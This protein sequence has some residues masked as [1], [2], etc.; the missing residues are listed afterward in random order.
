MAERSDTIILGILAHVSAL[1]AFVHVNEGTQN[2][3][4]YMILYLNLR[5]KEA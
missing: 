2:L 4:I 1:Q 5:K 3:Q